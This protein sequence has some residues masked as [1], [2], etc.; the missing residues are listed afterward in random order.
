MPPQ[1]LWGLSSSVFPIP[2]LSA[3]GNGAVYN[4][5]TASGPLANLS[6]ENGDF[7]TASS[8]AA[9]IQIKTAARVNQPNAFT[10]A[11]RQPDIEL[12]PRAWLNSRT[13]REFLFRHPQSRPGG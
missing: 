8:S 1:Y 6:T 13:R 5:T 11:V 12:Q 3:V 2:K 10:D 4:A 7:V 9:P